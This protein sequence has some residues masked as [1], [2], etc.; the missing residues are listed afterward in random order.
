MFTILIRFKVRLQTITLFQPVLHDWCNK[1]YGMCYLV[2]GMV[3]IKDTLLL[4]ICPMPYNRIKNVLSAFPS[5]KL[6]CYLESNEHA[7]EQGLTAVYNTEVLFGFPG[8]NDSKTN[9]SYSIKV[10]DS[11]YRQCYCWPMM[12]VSHLK[13]VY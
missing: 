13:F 12:V 9:T 11:A 7:T 8:T 5:F 6:L 3:H 10:N 1:G 2:C 4:I